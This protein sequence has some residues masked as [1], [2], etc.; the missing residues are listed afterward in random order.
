MQ[1]R[2]RERSISEVDA[3]HIGAESRHGLSENAA[4][5][6]DVD[7]AS[8]DEFTVARDIA[9]TQRINVM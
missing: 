9:Q 6:T 2:D 4:T 7:D 8:S 5:A 1:A 3:Q